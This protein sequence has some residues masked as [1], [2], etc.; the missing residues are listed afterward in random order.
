MSALIAIEMP[1]HCKIAHLAPL[2]AAV[3]DYPVSGYSRFS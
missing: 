3:L 2:A 1:L